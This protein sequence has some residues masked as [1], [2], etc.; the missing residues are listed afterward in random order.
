MEKKDFELIDPLK[1]YEDRIGIAKL[2]ETV[3]AWGNRTKKWLACS[4]QEIDEETKKRFNTKH[5]IGF[6]VNYGD[7][8]TYGLFSVEQITKWL[9][10]PDLLLYKLGGTRE[11]IVHKQK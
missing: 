6:W 9:E 10:T 4:P 11:R 3:G 8:E 7:D 5:P 1:E 2:K